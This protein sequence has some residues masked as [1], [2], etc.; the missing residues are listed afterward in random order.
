MCDNMKRKNCGTPMKILFV[1]NFS[2]WMKL[3]LEHLIAGYRRAGFQVVTADY[4]DMAKWHHISLPQ[5]F[6]NELRQRSLEKTVKREAPDICFF[7]GSIPFDLDR[8]KSY[9]NGLIVF[10][11]YDGPRRRD[12]DFFAELSKKC[13]LLTVSGYVERELKKR[14]CQSFYLPHGV[15]TD[16]YHPDGGSPTSYPAEISFIGRATKRRVEICEKTN[17]PIALYGDRWKKTSLASMCSY[18]EN[19]YDRDVVSI[20]RDSA[21]M[22]NILQEP[23]NEYRT[24]LSLQC[25]AVPSTAS[26]LCAEYVEEFPG[27]FEEGNEVLLFRD[28]AELPELLKKITSDR[29][30]ATSIGEAGRKRC[31]AEHTHFHRAQQFLD[32]IS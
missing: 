10:H 3:H 19:V 22:I 24:I 17:L 21:A 14:N 4:H 20:Y 18:D 23:L 7:A 15:D 9:F 5:T 16:F 12:M 25:F 30:W 27:S 31:L 1:G 29:K 11:D 28:P 6:A 2:I 8:L 26:C 13:M 32:F